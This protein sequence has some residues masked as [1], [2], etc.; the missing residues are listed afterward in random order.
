MTLFKVQFPLFPLQSPTPSSKH[1][2]SVLKTVK[3]NYL[4][5]NHFV[6]ISTATGLDFTLLGHLQA[7]EKIYIEEHHV[8]VTV[9]KMWTEISG[10]QLY[11]SEEI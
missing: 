1:F 8:T 7:G 6:L 10:L 4:V 5:N 3:D 2:H 11:Y 9:M